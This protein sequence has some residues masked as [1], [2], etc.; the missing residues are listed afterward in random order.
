MD[1]GLSHHECQSALLTDSE[2]GW[3]IRLS[4]RLWSMLIGRRAKGDCRRRLNC[5]LVEVS[6]DFRPT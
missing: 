1:E 2:S 4:T 6:W 5:H 3:K